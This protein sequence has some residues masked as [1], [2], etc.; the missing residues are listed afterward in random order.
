MCQLL[1]DLLTG[2]DDLADIDKRLVEM[3]ALIMEAY[4]KSTP[5][6]ARCS[7]PHQE[8]KAMVLDELEGN[9][10]SRYSDKPALTQETISKAPAAQII[11]QL[12]RMVVSE[13]QQCTAEQLGRDHI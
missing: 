8:L 7:Q 11:M 9:L 12:R 1:L 2:N 6:A 13:T 3:M 5:V 4:G 10:F